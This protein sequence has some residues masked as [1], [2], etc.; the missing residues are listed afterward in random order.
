MMVE[1][2]SKYGRVAGLPQSFQP[3]V[4]FVPGSKRQ[5]LGSLQDRYNEIVLHAWDEASAPNTIEAFYMHAHAD[6][7]YKAEVRT[8]HALFVRSYGLRERV[9]L[10]SYDP[11]SVDGPFTTVV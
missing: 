10:L 11:Q 1:Q 3:Y 8:A 6:E 9:P 2:E 5:V 7:G 4:P